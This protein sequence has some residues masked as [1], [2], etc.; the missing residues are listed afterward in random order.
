MVVSLGCKCLM[1][2]SHTSSFLF[3]LFFVCFLMDAH[4]PSNYNQ[5]RRKISEEEQVKKSNVYSQKSRILMTPFDCKVEKCEYFS[6]RVKNSKIYGTSVV[7]LTY[8]LSLCQKCA[9]Q[10][11]KPPRAPSK[12]LLL[13]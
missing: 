3:V 11:A 7:A 6:K 8:Q 2:P 4:K 10:R 1:K 12:L 5:G 13:T 9:V